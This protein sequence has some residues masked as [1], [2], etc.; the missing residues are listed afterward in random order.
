M[1]CICLLRLK[2]SKFHMDIVLYLCF[3]FF[4]QQQSKSNRSMRTSQLHNQDKNSSFTSTGAQRYE[5]M[6]S[7]SNKRTPTVKPSIVNQMMRNPTNTAVLAEYKVQSDN[8]VTPTEVATRRADRIAKEKLNKAVSISDTIHL[9]LVDQNKLD[10]RVL[11]Q[12]IFT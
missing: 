8:S 1:F 7:V 5:I 10:R 6:K 2:K 3:S 9:C 4:F 12:N 11:Y